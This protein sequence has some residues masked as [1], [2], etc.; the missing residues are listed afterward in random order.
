MEL[1]EILKQLAVIFALAFLTES[2]VEYLFGEIANH[3]D[4]LAPFKWLLMYIAAAV[5]VGV[6]FWYQL[7]LIAMIGESAI[8]PVG[9]IFTGLIIGRGANYAHQFVSQYF[10]K[11][12]K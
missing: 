10:P 6:S 12:A 2:L 9:V 11:S 1:V 7:D 4:K 3:S 5:G 8:T